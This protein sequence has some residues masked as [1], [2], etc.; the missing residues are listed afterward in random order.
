MLMTN[1]GRPRG[2]LGLAVAQRIADE[3]QSRRLTYTE[4]A[5]LMAQHGRDVG[6]EAVGRMANGT[7]SIDID[8]LG[9]IAASLGVPVVDLLIPTEVDEGRWKVDVDPKRGRFTY[10]YPRE[11]DHTPLAELLEIV[12][13]MVRLGDNLRTAT[14]HEI[15]TERGS[16]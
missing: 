14:H 15:T 8:E 12:R 4:F 11:T 5:R 13:L 7:R 3:M 2:E 1:R 6:P 10:T 9:A 16:K